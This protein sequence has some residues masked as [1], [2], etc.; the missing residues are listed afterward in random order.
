M[1]EG[2][3]T[4]MTRFA[5]NI[6]TIFMIL[7]LLI[8]A[9]LCQVTSTRI[10]GDTNLSKEPNTNVMVNKIVDG[11]N[12]YP[13]IIYKINI[14]KV[15]YFDFVLA[16]DSSGS[17]SYGQE[18]SEAHAVAGAVPLFISDIVSNNLYR[19]K[20][21]NL[22]IISFDDNLDFAYNGSKE[23][24]PFKNKYTKL[25][26]LINVT[27]VKK[28][29]EIHN[30][31]FGDNN[32]NFDYYANETEFTNFSVPIE[33]SINILDDVRQDRLHRISKFMILVTGKGEITNCSEELI[34]EA[35]AKNYSIYV[36]AMDLIE[37]DYDALKMKEQLKKLS[38]FD[39]FGWYRLQYV[40]MGSTPEELK[41]NLLISLQKSLQ[42]AVKAPAARNVRISESFY[43]YIRPIPDHISVNG[44]TG[45]IRNLEYDPEDNLIS[46]E[47][48]Q[49]LFPE[50]E[51]IVAIPADLHLSGLPIS[52][53]NGSMPFSTGM[54]NKSTPP[55]A[56]NYLW[57]DGYY[58][59]IPLTENVIDLDINSQ[60]KDNL[61]SND[62][63]QQGSSFNFIG[64][65]KRFMGA[66]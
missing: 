57:F 42:N 36:I 61:L 40:P 43:P 27:E 38:E 7:L 31:V 20:N 11:S 23:F 39:E 37:E 2:N 18:N 52:I 12:G 19:N 58:G 63:I 56:I 51:T 15:D 44:I 16:L 26:R 34:Q 4:M 8:N 22:S 41:N 62:P 10:S 65:L 66:N 9:G 35:R 1:K 50:S 54:I 49:G 13:N 3:I 30:D 32:D 45:K 28:D 25:A 47:L 59:N 48:E 53:T 60:S 55:S 14:P 46:F 64:I 33:S 17:F 24:D 29:I 6:S 21:I 5:L